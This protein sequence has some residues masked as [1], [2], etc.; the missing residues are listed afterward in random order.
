MSFGA[1]DNS[2]LD[3]LANVGGPDLASCRDRLAAIQVEALERRAAL[4]PQIAAVEGLTDAEAARALESTVWNLPFSFWQFLGVTRCGWLPASDATDVRLFDFLFFE[5]P[6]YS[7]PASQRRFLPYYYQAYTEFGYPAIRSDHFAHLLET[8]P[9]SL[10]EALPGVPIEFHPEVMQDIASWVKTAGSRLMFVYGEYDPW[11]AGAFELGNATDSFV[12]V[13]PKGT[14]SASIASL[15]ASD[16]L[17]ARAIVMRWA[18][19]AN[20]PTAM[21]P[22]MPPSMLLSEPEPEPR[23]LPPVPSLFDAP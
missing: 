20:A 7:D 11:T 5:V 17:A 21:A 6:G 13:Q 8:K 18:G 19:V 2:Y 1:P 3:F 22:I 23:A 12:F 10:A 9:W 15:S 14:H 4:I 16:Q